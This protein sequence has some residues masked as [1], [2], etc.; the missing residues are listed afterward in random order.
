MEFAIDDAKFFKSCI[1]A[2]VNLVDE[3]TFVLSEEGLHLRSMDPSQIAMVDFI[4]P[5]KAFSKLNVQ[6]KVSISVN[7]VDFSKILAR[8]RPDDKLTVKL[9][10]EESRLVLEFKGDSKRHFK[11][12]LIDAPSNL[13]KEPKIEFDA[14]V[15][16]KGGA[17]KCML[18]DAGLLSSHVVLHALDSEFIIEAHG[19][20]GDLH[21]LT[22]GSSKDVAEL[23]VTGETRAM[24]PFE[25]MDDLTRACPDDGVMSLNLK[26]DSPVKVQYQIGD[27][28]LSYYLAPRVENV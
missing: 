8:A 18:Q 15:R 26:T 16:I 25:Y 11:L 1:E 3:G 22:P 10:E 24:F 4:L 21:S 5:K 28:L 27:A 12:P 17:M 19:D 7:L 14:M 2:V 13:P 23:K 9:D 6:D 20:A